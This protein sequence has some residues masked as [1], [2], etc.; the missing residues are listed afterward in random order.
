MCKSLYGTIRNDIILSGTLNILNE[1]L[2]QIPVFPLSFKNGL[3]DHLRS[4][5]LYIYHN[6]S[7]SSGK[8]FGIT[9]LRNPT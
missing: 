7:D 3:L 4:I 2:L 6:I 8:T 1:T 5:T 9:T